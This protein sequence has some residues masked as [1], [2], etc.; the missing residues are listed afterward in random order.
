V[1]PPPSTSGP[2][3]WYEGTGWNGSGAPLVVDDDAAEADGEPARP[4]PE[5]IHDALRAATFWADHDRGRLDDRPPQDF[6]LLDD[7]LIACS[8]TPG[9]IQ[10]ARKDLQ[11]GLLE[12]G[13]DLDLTSVQLPSPPTPPQTALERDEILYVIQTSTGTAPDRLPGLLAGWGNEVALVAVAE[14]TDASLG[15]VSAWPE[16]TGSYSD[17]YY[18]VGTWLKAWLAGD[19][20]AYARTPSGVPPPHP[21]RVKWLILPDDDTWVNTRG[22]ERV[23]ST[24]PSDVP[25]VLGHVLPHVFS[26]VSHLSGGAGKV[27]SAGSFLNFVPALW[28]EREGGSTSEHGGHCSRREVNGGLWDDVLLSE[29]ATLGL[30]ASLVSSMRFHSGPDELRGSGSTHADPMTIL[31]ALAI[32]RV[33][34]DK[35]AR[36]TQIV[37]EWE[38]GRYP[39]AGAAWGNIEVPAGSCH[40]FYQ[41]D[42]AAEGVGRSTLAGR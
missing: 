34:G 25:V 1:R 39:M 2:K 8:H 13:R 24:L 28:P 6:A 26:D 15:L 7:W 3:A 19:P 31:D 21:D 14:K 16:D 41:G 40:R 12:D 32:H 33:C 20:A 22:L 30:G 27:F 10:E 35:H 18:R 42:N 5:A 38:M 36:Y 17:T 4:S 37:R 11:P 9:C 23:L 29:C